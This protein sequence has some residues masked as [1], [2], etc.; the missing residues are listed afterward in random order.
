M[1][2]GL[3]LGR[4]YVSMQKWSRAHVFGKVVMLTDVFW[5]NRDAYTIIGFYKLSMC[6]ILI[7]MSL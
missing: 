7:H 4:L 3:E 5:S 2:D 6:Y 1:L